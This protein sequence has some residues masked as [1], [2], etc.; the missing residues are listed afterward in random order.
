MTPRDWNASTYHQVSTPH[1]HW[2][3]QVLDRLELRGD[4]TVLDAGCGTGRITQQL[5]DRWPG[6]R[7]IAVDGSPAMARRARET[8]DPARATVLCQDLLELTLDE[9]AG[10]AISTATFHR[11]ADHDALFARIHD[12][13]I[14]GAPFVAQCGGAGNI[15]D[16]M[17]VLDRVG[18]Q[19]PFAAAMAGWAG[20]WHYATPEDTTRRLDRAGFDVARCWLNPDPVTPDHPRDF[21]EAVVLGSHLERLE[22]GLRDAY[23]D[24]VWEGLGAEARMD[25]V[26][27]NWIA[28][29]R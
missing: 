16:V 3:R 5:L 11:I 17:A 9:P 13:L 2:G 10:A 21:L 26:R 22:P 18:R 8:L 28:R 27:L 15:A 20:P 19:A 6:I 12:A 25:Y 4:E 23:V 24:A 1:Q 29:R 7:A 14:P